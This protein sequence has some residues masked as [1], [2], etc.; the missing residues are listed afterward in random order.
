MANNY[1]FIKAPDDWNGYMPNN[2]SILLHHLNYWLSHGKR[3]IPDCAVIHHING[4][5]LDNRPENLFMFPN[6]S[7]HIWYH[8]KFL[9]QAYWKGKKHSIEYKLMMSEALKGKRK[10]V[11]NPMYGKPAV[12]RRAV[13]C[14]ETGQIF[15]S[16]AEA[17]AFIGKSGIKSVLSGRSKTCGGYHWVYA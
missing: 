12:N 9:Q 6:K 15:S 5:K 11:N 1:K 14:L 13:K 17:E 16:I 4:N 2:K 7:M 8:N 10:G 3:P